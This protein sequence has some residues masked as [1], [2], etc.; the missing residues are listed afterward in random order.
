LSGVLRNIGM[1]SGATVLGNGDL[2]LILDVKTIADRAGHRSTIEALALS[3]GDNRQMRSGDS[4]RPA[5]A[6]M[7]VYET[8]KHDTGQQANCARMAI[9]LPLVERIERV[10]LNT[11]EYTEGR[12]VLQYRGELILLE[13][14]GDVLAEKHFNNTAAEVCDQR[15]MPCA[16]LPGAVAPCGESSGAMVTV[17][18]CLRTGMSAPKRFGIVVRRVLDVSAGTLLAENSE[19][20]MCQLAMVEDRVTTV[21]ASTGAHVELSSTVALQEVA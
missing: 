12:A 13:D 1:Y 21:R 8:S 17:M 6:T 16:S 5:E 3:G 14:Q 4:A 7:V 2:A 18:I 20:G 19:L 15:A 10:P 9:P 11:I